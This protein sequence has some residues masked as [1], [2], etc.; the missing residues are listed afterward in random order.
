M[1]IRDS[2]SRGSRAFLQRPFHQIS[3]GFFG[4]VNQTYRMAERITLRKSLSCHSNRFVKDI[5]LSAFQIRSGQYSFGGAV[6]KFNT[7][8]DK[9]GF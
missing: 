2:Y 9:N 3:N 1:Q 8:H 5:S 7:C 6:S 4:K